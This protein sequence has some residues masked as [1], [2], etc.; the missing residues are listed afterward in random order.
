MDAIVHPLA[1]VLQGPVLYLVA[2]FW[3]FEDPRHLAVHRIR[4]AEKLAEPAARVP[5]GFEL[6]AYLAG[7]P[8]EISEGKMIR[9]EALFERFTAQHLRETPL[10]V[11]QT[12]R[13]EKDGRVRVVATMR[14]SERLVWWLLGFGGNV[15]VVGPRGLRERVR[16]EIRGAGAR[17]E[18][19][20]RG[21]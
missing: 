13:D 14:E 9:L 7:S 1:L 18:R 10:S 20:A 12:M 17:Y 16:E 6:D 8:L 21:R 19:E 4:S 11:D 2:T 5:K 3:D 15:E